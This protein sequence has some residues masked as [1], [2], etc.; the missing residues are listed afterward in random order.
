[1]VTETILENQT[2]VAPV[3]VIVK[4]ETKDTVDA[5]P[6]TD[7]LRRKFVDVSGSTGARAAASSDRSP[8]DIGNEKN[9]KKTYSNTSG[10]QAPDLQP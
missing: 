10:K 9:N 2:P 1:M 5:G 8:T 3:S 7:S 4:E 6:E